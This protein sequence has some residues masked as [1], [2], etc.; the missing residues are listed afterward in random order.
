[1]KNGSWAA[2][3]FSAIDLGDKRLNERLIKLCDSLSESPESPINQ[4]CQDWSE[5]KA[6]YRFFKNEKVDPEEIV[7]S[8]RAKTIE[9]VEKHKTI[10]AL[11]DTSYIIY[12]HHPKTTGLGKLTMVKG[13]RIAEVYSKGLLMHICLAVTTDGLPLGL[14]D[15][16][17]LI[18][19][20]TKGG[21]RI[22]NR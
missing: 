5:T 20:K 1:M 9:R 19:R 21:L 16:D 6:A 18:S 8:H 7:S 13:K 10:L 14:L 2:N 15:Q 3:E 11:Q 17:I 4:T 12:T 22:F